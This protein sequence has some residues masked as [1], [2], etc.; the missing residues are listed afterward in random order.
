MVTVTKDGHTLWLEAPKH[1]AKRETANKPQAN[2][3]TGYFIGKAQPRGRRIRIRQSYAQAGSHRR[4]AC[5]AGTKGKQSKR[6]AARNPASAR[7]RVSRNPRQ[8]STC[9]IMT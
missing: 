6:C 9:T 2:R 3:I 7:L 5:S 4:I 1:R 8:L